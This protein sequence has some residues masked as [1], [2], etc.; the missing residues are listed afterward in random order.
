MN[1]V[2]HTD[3]GPHLPPLEST[4]EMPAYWFS[5]QGL[6]FRKRFLQSVLSE[7]SQPSRKTFSNGL[8]RDRLC[9]RNQPDTIYP[10]SGRESCSMKPFIHAP[11]VVADRTAR[12][13][14][15]PVLN[16]DCLRRIT[17]S[18]AIIVPKVPGNWQ[19]IGA[20][21]LSTGQE[22]NSTDHGPDDAPFSSIRIEQ[23]VVANRTEID[24][25]HL[26]GIDP[27]PFNLSA[28]ET[29]QVKM[30]LVAV[31]STYHTGPL[32]ETCSQLV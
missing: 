23:V 32:L 31:T 11:H 24:D 9:R 7:D 30:G 17:L 21:S 16:T 28:N 26:C 12:F 25:R 1:Q 19:S 22:C 18:P 4:D 14:I 6:H 27:M 8:D 5:S 29:S 15:H 3:Y 10:T 2:E 20:A 13:C